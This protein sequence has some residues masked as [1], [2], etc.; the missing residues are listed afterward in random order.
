MGYSNRVLKYLDYD[1]VATLSVVFLVAFGLVSIYILSLSNDANDSQNFEK[2]L[3]FL[4][5]ALVFF[6]ILSQ[7]DYR[8]WKSYSA[9]VYLLG[10]ILLILVLLFGKE[11]RGTS[12]WFSLG[13]FNFQPVEL[14]KLFLVI[15]LANYFSRQHSLGIHLK[16]VLVSFFY[17]LIPVVLAAWQPDMGSA[18]VMFVIWFCMLF[19]AGLEKKYIFALL[20]IVI[21][22]PIFSWNIVLK[23]YQKERIVAFV[24]PG[25]DPLGSGYNVI[26]S[27]VAVG[28]G[29]I[30][31]KGLG[32]GSQ[33]R[34][35]FLPEKHTDF[36]FAT[37]AEESG[38]VG[39]LILIGL[40]ILLFFRLK[41]TAEHS[42]DGFGRLIVGGIMAV[43][44]FQVFVNV[45]M[46]VGIMPI[47]GLSLPFISYGGS[48]L[49][50][51]M[52]AFGLAQSVW[53]RRKKETTLLVDEY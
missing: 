47:A 12:G 21:L 19:L 45:G 20:A 36:I 41:I 51:A 50:V 5:I 53:K 40:F 23:E 17:V 49:I 26:Q 1:W 13:F 31:G 29:G 52:S 33:S 4:A 32:H 35:N 42:R 34:L 15:S 46:N 2:Q 10:V 37:I 39:S 30:W 11:I 44:I 48:F 3:I 43:I 24:D 27:M 18:M 7:L 38:L 14:M 22:I 8:I 25:K 6:V 28:S 16:N 9:L